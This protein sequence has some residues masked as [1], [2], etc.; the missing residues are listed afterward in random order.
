MVDEVNTV[1]EAGGARNPGDAREVLPGECRLVRSAGSWLARLAVNLPDRPG[2]LVDLAALAA[3]LGVNIER[4]EYDRGAHPHRVELS[5]RAADAQ[6]AGKTLDRLAARGFLEAPASE[7]AEPAL[8]TDV[9]GVLCFKVALKNRPG[10][11]A[12]LAA[13][14][15]ALQANVIH[16]RY[17][18]EQDPEMAEASV[19]LSG[20]ERVLSS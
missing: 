14:F 16:M 19:S 9:D 10:T 5:L 3:S 2:V 15:R 13:R 8:I 11:L 12:E 6:R 20:A 7:E 1:A 4:L 17:D 18:V